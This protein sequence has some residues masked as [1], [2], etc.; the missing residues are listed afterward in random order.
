MGHYGRM[1]SRP[2]P[3]PDP[4]TL[5][6]AATLRAERARLG[7]TLKEVADATGQLTSGGISRSQVGKMLAGE[8]PIGVGELDRL[9]MALNLSIGEVV[10]AADRATRD[11]LDSYAALEAS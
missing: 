2:T 1:S 4:F 5:Q 9:C 7:M 10:I 11:R 8:K 6:L 3:A